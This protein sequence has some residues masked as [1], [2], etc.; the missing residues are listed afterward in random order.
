MTT[1]PAIR[2]LGSERLWLRDDHWKAGDKTWW[3]FPTGSGFSRT[4]VDPVDPVD[5]VEGTVCDPRVI[6]NDGVFRATGKF[7]RI[8]HREDSCTACAESVSNCSPWARTIPSARQALDDF[9]E[10]YWASTPRRQ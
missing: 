4:M 7:E 10:R 8:R 1:S 9:H 2:T 6:Y 3:L 5:P